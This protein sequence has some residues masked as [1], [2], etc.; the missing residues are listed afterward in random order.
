MSG[1]LAGILAQLA[2]N[3]VV[4][5]SVF[6]PAAAGLLNLG[7]AGFVLVGGYVAGG[8]TSLAGVPLLP[9]IAAGGAAAGAIAF[10]VSFPILRTRGVYMVLAT[11]AFAE[12]VGGV[13]LN[14]PALGGASGL[15]V[16]AYASLPVVLAVTVLVMAFVGWLL[17]TRFGLAMRA[18]HDDESVALLFG[19]NLR[20][21]QVFA[22]TAG[23]ALGG[24]GGGLIVHQFNFIDVQTTGI[25]FSIF[26]LLYVLMGGT[27]TAWGPIAGALF[28]TLVPEGLRRLSAT[29]P[30]LGFLEA[31][32][33]IVF[34]AA[35]VLVMMWRPEGLVTRTLVEQVFGALGRR[36]ERDSGRGPERDLGRR[37]GTRRE[38]SPPLDTAPRPEAGDG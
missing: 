8:L 34:G 23:G 22:F 35:V 32:R 25:M 15:S 26:V 13:L 4:A 37:A 27:Q 9:A 5:Y 19:T 11:F 28:F 29:I 6:L 18:V 10:L 30:A 21:T 31:S 3:I 7:A 1:Y 33:Y 17:A 24:I 20:L 16:S 2:I 14:I 38:T 36:P 12:V